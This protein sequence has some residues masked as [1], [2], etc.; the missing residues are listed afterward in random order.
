M[1]TTSE[2]CVDCTD[3]FNPK[4]LNGFD[5]GTRRKRCEAFGDYICDPIADEIRDYERAKDLAYTRFP[6]I[7]FFD[8]ADATLRFFRK[9]KEQSPTHGACINRIGVYTFGEGLKVVKKKENGF[10]LSDS[11]DVEV[12]DTEAKKFIEFI[13]GINPDFDGDILLDEMW[14]SHEN[15]K[16]Y[17]NYFLR[18]DMVEVAGSRFAYVSVIDCEECRYKLTDRG[19]EKVL[20]VSPL[21]TWDYLRRYTPEFLPVYPR[22]ERTK[23]G[24]MTTVIHVKNKVVQRKWYGLTDS[25]PSLRDQLLESQ[26]GQYYTENYANDFVPRTIIEIDSDS[27]DDGAD[28]FD[29]AV[30]ATY[31]N[32][33]TERKRVVIR[34][35]LREETPMTVHEVKSSTDFQEH[36]AMSDEAEEQIVKAHGWHKVLLGSPT[37]GRLGAS[38]EFSEIYRH[39][40]FTTI[41]PYRRKVLSGWHK[42]FEMIDEFM[43]G[44]KTVTAEMSLT[45]SDLFKDYLEATVIENKGEAPPDNNNN[46]NGAIGNV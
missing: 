7:P 30:K 3:N 45:C 29:D 8:N 42:A 10:V 11:D 21:W 9:M 19:E 15:L 14:M 46:D 6:I 12:D 34:R 43:N 41:R 39:F 44:S 36:R 17:G 26:Q 25:F 4:N 27:E 20:L 16:T 33:G 28:G 18:V 38:Q 32:R 40:N 31:T 23:P 5:I 37:P 2:N 22:V 35:R 24:V 1:S 13:E